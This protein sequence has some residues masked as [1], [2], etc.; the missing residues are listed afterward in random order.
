R[1][2]LSLALAGGVNLAAHG[3]DAVGAPVQTDAALL[4]LLRAEAALEQRCHRFRRD[5][6]AVVAHFDVKHRLAIDRFAAAAHGDLSRSDARRP[7]RL[8]GIDHE[9]AE[10]LRARDGR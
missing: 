9:I 2:A 3:D 7:N 8:G 1:G 10:G 6:F 5:A 4:L